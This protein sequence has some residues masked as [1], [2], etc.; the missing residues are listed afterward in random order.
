[1][2]VQLPTYQVTQLPNGFL[3]SVPCNLS[4]DFATLMLSCI[5]RACACPSGG[6]SNTDSSCWPKAPPTLPSLHSFPHCWLWLAFWQPPTRQK[7]LSGKL[8]PPS[9]GCFLPD[10]AQSP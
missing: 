2:A 5:S 3:S 4:P 9:A 7:A 8:A 10:P 1:M 6:H